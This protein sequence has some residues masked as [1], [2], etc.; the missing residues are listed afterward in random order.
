MAGTFTCTSQVATHPV[1]AY[2]H[3]RYDFK[4]MHLPKNYGS[5]LAIQ[6]TYAEF[7]FK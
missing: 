7:Y 6:S 5:H 1:L 4:Q 2:A 3:T